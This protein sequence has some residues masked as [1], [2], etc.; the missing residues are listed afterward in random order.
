[1]KIKK[2]LGGEN[3]NT[4]TVSK[5]TILGLAILAISSGINLLGGGNYLTGGILT[6]VG[7]LLL[8]LRT[9]LKID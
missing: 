3:P 8:V 6:G 9:Y 2:L 5:D 1:M 7:V 4:Y